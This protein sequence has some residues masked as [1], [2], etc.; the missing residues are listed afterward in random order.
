MGVLDSTV[1]NGSLEV[2]ADPTQPLEVATKRYVDNIDVVPE[3]HFD[4]DLDDDLANEVS[5]VGITPGFKAVLVFWIG[6]SLVHGHGYYEIEVATDAAFTAIVGNEQTKGTFAVFAGLVTGTMYYARVRGV[7]ADGAVG[8]WVTNVPVDAPVQ[9]EDDD[10]VSITADKITAGTITATIGIQ[11]PVITGGAIT[12]TTFTGGLFRTATT[13]ARIQMSGGASERI[14]F[15]NSLNQEIGYIRPE[16]N[17]SLQ[18]LSQ[19]A[20]SL[21]ALGVT[22]IDGGSAVTIDAPSVT[23][24]GFTPLTTGNHGHGF[25]GSTGSTNLGST[26]GPSQTFTGGS[27]V[28]SG[29]SGNQFLTGTGP[30]TA[31]HTHRMADHT[32]SLNNHAHT[33]NS[34]THFIGSHSH[35]FSI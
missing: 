30:A 14:T 27:S 22:N 35:S 21:Q 5:G 8:P 28:Q 6:S 9:A 17:N 32:H 31:G 16:G 10:I 13:G 34:H 11:S 33:L 4:E 2:E 18:L 1:V 12:G 25:G 7:R 24:N 19:N 29:L 20:L 26:G 15:I 3:G 23:I